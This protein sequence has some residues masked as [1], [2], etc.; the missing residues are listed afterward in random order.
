MAIHLDLPYL[1]S[2]V[3][4]QELSELRLINRSPDVERSLVSAT[5]VVGKWLHRALE[6]DLRFQGAPLHVFRPRSDAARADSQATL[7][8]RL[9]SLTLQDRVGEQELGP[10]LAYLRGAG[11]RD[12]AAIAVQEIVGRAFTPG[13]QSSEHSYRAARVV[14]GWPRQPWGALT[15]GVTR[16]LCRAKAQVAGAAHDDSGAIHATSIA[17]HNIVRSLDRLRERYLDGDRSRLGEAD[18]AAPAL[19]VRTALRR[20]TFPFLSRPVKEG[21]VFVI[22]LDRLHDGQANRDLVFLEREWS[23]CPAHKFVPNLLELAW[24]R[25]LAA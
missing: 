4:V 21:T 1:F 18:L 11:D 2:L 8:R 24:E 15:E 16:R 17:M 10:I 9:S 20:T 12:E 5:G 3:L 19:V 23:Q 13:Y 14:D 25:A 6:H 22:P 7:E